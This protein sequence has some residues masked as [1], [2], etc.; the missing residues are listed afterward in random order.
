MPYQLI[1]QT[2]DLQKLLQSLADA[3]VIGFD[4]EFISEGRYTPQLCLVQI[5]AGND[6]YL[7]DPLALSELESLWTLFCDGQRDIVVHA[8]RSEMEFCHRAIGRLPKHVFDVQLA[9]GI[10]GLDFP[11]SFRSVLERFLKLDLPKA[12]ARTVWDK[13]PLTA[14]QIQYALDDVRY[15]PKLAEILTQQL[16]RRGR[17][18]WF[19]Q[20][21]TRIQSQLFQ[22]FEHSRTERWRALPKISRLKPRELAIV[23]A[24]WQWRNQAAQRSNKPPGRILRDDLL[25]ELAKRG[26]ADTL[27]MEAIRGFQ[28]RDLIRI[29]PELST[30]IQAAL[31]QPKEQWP[32]LSHRPAFSHH[33]AMTQFLYAALCSL[34]KQHGIA[35]QLVGTQT[36]VQDLIAAE[37]GTLP[38]GI[39]PRLQEGWRKQLVGTVLHD[40]LHGRLVMRLDIKNPD[41][42]LHFEPFREK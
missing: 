28:Q 27:R 3:S 26:T 41:E 38:N 9:A 11:A 30:T 2:S 42:P 15:L 29:L 25:V 12:E 35:P 8:C 10:L 18:E 22:D 6:L 4:T 17:Y 20:E 24:L 37:L 31:D 21:T 16:R 36:D 19:Q 32:S 34:C 39:Q 23:Q 5:S 33:S 1:T 7:L 13:R 14:Q 40:L